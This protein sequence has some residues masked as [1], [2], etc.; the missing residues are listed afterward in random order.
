[1]RQQPDFLDTVS[2]PPAILR[3]A[4]L[5]RRSMDDEERRERMTELTESFP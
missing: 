4:E 2:F 5:A 3:P 1:M